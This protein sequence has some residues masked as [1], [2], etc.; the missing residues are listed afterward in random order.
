M[1]I[2]FSR[3]NNRWI[4]LVLLLIAAL[5]V[6]CTP[7]QDDEVALYPADMPARPH[8]IYLTPDDAVHGLLTV[9]RARSLGFTL[10]P[11]WADVRQAARTRPLDVLLVEQSEFAKL[12]AAD[13]L[14]LRRRLDEGLLVGGVGI[15]IEPFSAALGLPN[16]RDPGEALIPVGDD[17][18]LI[19]GAQI[20]GTPEDIAAMRAANWLEHALRGEPVQLHSGR[21]SG[22]SVGRSRGKLATERD[23]DFFL[24]NLHNWI[25]GT[26]KNRME[27]Q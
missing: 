26:Y 9:E 16:L 3:M 20:I 23:M 12:S 1:R 10:Y 13:L 11:R 24:M 6:A 15:D 14:W 8:I 18:Y 21:T 5:G 4:V 22:A 25:E 19:F 2:K 27:V 17:G 7:V